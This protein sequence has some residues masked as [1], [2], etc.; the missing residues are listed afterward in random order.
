MAP[1]TTIVFGVSGNVGSRTACTAESLGAKV[2]LA[3]R[4]LR[5]PV[6]DLKPEEEASRNFQRIQADLTRPESIEAAVRSTEAKHAFFYLIH[7]SP[8]HMRS[9]V[10]ALKVSGIEFVVFLSSIGAQ[11]DIKSIPSSS[12]L[13]YLHAQVELVLDEIFGAKG[14]V[15]IRPGYFNT[16]AVG[17]WSKML[18]E[19]EVKMAYPEATWDWIAPEDIGKV[20]EAN[21]GKNAIYL[22]GPKFVSQRDA[23]IIFGRGLGKEIKVTTVDEDTEIDEMASRIPRPAAEMIIKAIGRSYRVDNPSDDVYS[24]TY[25]EGAANLRKY[26][27]PPTSLE[28]WAEKNMGLFSS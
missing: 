15:A 8:D 25:E 1:P 7:E 3:S 18:R 17:F 27:D 9:V 4:D 23:A 28:E 19:G 26:V 20:I 14:Y 16:N 13:P 11:G 5:K 12:G 10:K 22:C 6:R 2:I 24:S 21:A